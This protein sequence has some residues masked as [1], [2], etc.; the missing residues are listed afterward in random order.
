M[1]KYN[2]SKTPT[3]YNSRFY[4]IWSNMKTRCN[5]KKVKSFSDYGGR[6]ITVCNKW[7]TFGGFFDDMYESYINTNAEDKNL[8]L[9]RIDNSKNYEVVNCRWSTKTEQARNTRNIENAQKVSYNGYTKTIREWAEIIGIKRT[10][11]D[12]RINNYKWD[13]KR[14]LTK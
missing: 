7:N 11:L 5:N 3:L 2:F 6:G 4:K 8:T 9:D 12:M 1:E 14:A 10:T 13:I